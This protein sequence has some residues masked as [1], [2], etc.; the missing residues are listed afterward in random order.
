MATI[1][2]PIRHLRVA[3]LDDQRVDQQHRIDGVEWAVL[4]GGHVLDDRVGDLGDRLPGELGAVELGQVALDLADGEALG[5]EGDDIGGN[6]LEAT[7]VL[8]HRRRLEG[9]VAVPGNAQL[10]GP[11]V[12]GDRLGVAAVAGVAR[13]AAGRVIRFVAEMIS[14][15]DLQAGLEHLA[16]HVGQK[17]VLTGQ[18]D[19]LGACSTHQLLGEAA[20]RHVLLHRRQERLTSRCVSHRRDPLWPPAF[21]RGPLDHAGY[22][23]FR[24]VPPLAMRVCARGI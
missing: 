11:D 6:A 19:A 23:K 15:L 5:I 4:P 9:A 1:D 10:H 16:D 17:A 24:T 13:A 20:H 21:S 12:G 7:T 2:G 3:D 18:L 8:G 22:T 14:Q